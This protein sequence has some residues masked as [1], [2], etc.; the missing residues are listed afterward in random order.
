MIGSFFSWSC[1]DSLG[2]SINDKTKPLE[3]CML[4]NFL[5]CFSR[6]WVYKHVPGAI[7]CPCF[8]SRVRA[9][10]RDMAGQPHLGTSGFSRPANISPPRP[11]E[12][13]QLLCLLSLQ[14]T[15]CLKGREGALGCLWGGAGSRPRALAPRQ[16]LHQWSFR[17]HF[18]PPWLATLGKLALGAVKKNENAGM[19]NSNNPNNLRPAVLANRTI[20]GICF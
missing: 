15:H 10:P 2:F 3:N 14:L 12:R 17:S 20:K 18:L 16:K 1:R 9:E 6:S 5:S 4:A 19:N 11:Q 8:K 13:L 7:G